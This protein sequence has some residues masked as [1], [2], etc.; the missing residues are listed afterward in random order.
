MPKSSHKVRPSLDFIPSAYNSLVRS[1]VIFLLPT[2]L[3]FKTSIRDIQADNLINLVELYEQF[4]Q[5]KVKFLIAFRHPHIDDP[6]CLA[7]MTWRLLPQAA[8]AQGISLPESHFHFIYDRG[9]PLWAGSH[10]G[11]LYSRLGG[12]PIMRG[13]LDLMGLRSIRQLFTSGKFP[14][15]ASPE[16]ATNGHNGIISPLEPGISQMAFWCV[17]DLIKLDQ[18]QEVVILPIGIQYTYID[19]P[20]QALTKLLSELEADSGLEPM[21][22]VEVKNDTP[23]TAVLYQRLLRLGG[24]LLTKMEEFY[25]QFYRYQIP[26]IATEPLNNENLVQRLN[27]LL[28][29]ALNVAEDYFKIQPKGNFIDRCRRLEQ[30]SWDYIYRDDIKDMTTLSPLEFGL[31]D[32]IAQESEMRIWHMRL[33]ESFVAVTGSYVKE[34]LSVER[35]AETTLLL[36]DMLARVKGENAFFR[37]K[38]GD[39]KVQITIG[40]P[41]SVSSRWQ[42]YKTNRRNAVDRLTQDLQSSLQGMI[43][44]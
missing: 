21:P 9:I 28:N 38:L 30:A 14:L 12:T 3:R 34:N 8:R 32:R 15:A 35:F 22:S 43:K 16:G 31:A 23:N 27:F 18:A 41:L 6:L 26:A 17:E 24:H 19:P 5:G 13:K 39:Q 10:I 29:A 1:I 4:N 20:W 7:Y 25:H 33:V 36:W 40:E 44:N 2:W 42:D 37:P 11:W